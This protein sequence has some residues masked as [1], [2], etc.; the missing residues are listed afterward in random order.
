MPPAR[1][2]LPRDR[3]GCSDRKSAGR[4]DRDRRGPASGHLQGR[5]GWCVLVGTTE[6]PGLQGCPLKRGGRPPVARHRRPDPPLGHRRPSKPAPR[7]ATSRPV[8][9][10]GLGTM[11]VDGPARPRTPPRAGR[12]VRQTLPVA[13]TRPAG[14]RRRRMRQT[15]GGR[16]CRSVRARRRRAAL[17][18]RCP[19]PVPRRMR[20]RPRPRRAP[21]GGRTRRRSSGR[22]AGCPRAIPSHPSLGRSRRTG[23]AWVDSY[24]MIGPTATRPSDVHTTD[25]TA[26]WLRDRKDGIL[27]GGASFVRATS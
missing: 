12:P 19:P 3:I 21:R 6:G 13:R 20:H 9:V 4:P 18:K 22:P 25:A 26:A 14:R 7:R 27:A 17:G 8:P 16:R 23:S 5:C 1:P 2:C 10:P 11:P 24:R 15:G